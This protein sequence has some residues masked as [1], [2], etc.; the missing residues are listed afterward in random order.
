MKNY[1][2]IKVAEQYVGTID[3]E[4]WIVGDEL[5][6]DF[7][8]R[9]PHGYFPVGSVVRVTIEKVEEMPE[10]KIGQVWRHRREHFLAVVIG[11][12][13]ER[14]RV[15]VADI[16]SPI[17]GTDPVFVLDDLHERFDFVCDI[18]EVGR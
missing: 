4:G 18:N 14:V 9:H 17:H 16:K 3:N 7:Q 5:V 12:D 8:V 10:V 6:P 15:I 1:K 11:L 2:T 13:A